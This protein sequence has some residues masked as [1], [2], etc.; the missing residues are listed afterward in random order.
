MHFLNNLKVGRRMALAFGLLTLIIFFLGGLGYVS[1]I[2][3]DSSADEIVMVRLPSLDSVLVMEY[4]L[5]KLISAQR[6]LL[7]PRNTM[8]VRT[9][10]YS[11]I[12]AARKSY[13]E[14]ADLYAPLPQTPEESREWQS[15]LDVLSKWRSVNDVFLSQ[16][17][18]IDA[19]GILNADE[20]LGYIQMF[21]SD[22]Y[23]L[24]NRVANYIL[25]G[26]SFD[27]GEDHRECNF[28]R[29][30][31]SFSTSNRNL[32]SA[33]KSMNEPHRNFH[34]S[35]VKIR[36]SMEE[37]DRDGALRIFNGEMQPAAESVFEIFFVFLDEAF[38]VQE[39]QDG[40]TR[41][42]VEEILPLQER[43]M[44]HLDRVVEINREI[45]TREGAALQALSERNKRLTLVA[46]FVALGLSLSFGVI[47]TR[48]IVLPLG[49]SGRMFKSISD[50]DMTRT[51]PPDLLNRKDELGDMGRQMGEMANSLREVFSRLNGGVETLAS[52]STELSSIS[53]QTAQ[54]AQESSTLSESVAAAAEEMTTSAK[55]MA[56]K[57]EVSSGNLNSVASAME[58]MTSTIGEIATN[59]AKANTST[60]ESVKS[61][62][63]FARMMQELGG[64]AQ[65]IGKVTETINGISDQTNLLALNATI[66]AARAGEAGKGFAVV[67]GEIKELAGQT[68]RATGD[69]REK[70]TGIQSASERATAD[71]EG[72]VSGIQNVNHIVGTIAAAIEEQSSAIRE[73]ASNIASASSMVE[74]ANGQSGEMN[75]VS[76][77]IA[78]DMA[79]VSAAASQVESASNQVQETVRELSALSEEIREMM[80]RFK[81]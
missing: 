52:S 6:M 66:E 55:A 72:I 7:N 23:A 26:E 51:V 28:G 19:T 38:Q 70:I 9:I 33:L 41:M 46:L 2:R 30:L 22:H 39:M 17:Q 32:Q 67:A 71:I 75:Q 16:S 27:G 57:M 21:R 12:D 5:E 36:K 24:M 42:L 1:S 25:L 63:G 15:F 50:G 3:T 29:W 35:I 40:M 78:R 37:G 31:V 58:E 43:A 59:T 68:A 34:E 10:A 45:A 56:H 11:N 49:Q 64:A 47:I 13:G 74:E 62:E 60:E 81:V 69:I 14:A 18:E 65:E 20:L 61:I 53:E 8:E 4:Q 77:E 73:V 48:S 76:G 79:S 54:S 80:R 44:A